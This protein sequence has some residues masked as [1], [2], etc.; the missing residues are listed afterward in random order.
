[1]PKTNRGPRVDTRLHPD[2]LD[3]LEQLCRK[4]SMT[5]TA[6]VRE[7]ILWYLHSHERVEDEKRTSEI[8]LLFKKMTDRICGYLYKVGVDSNTTM[9]FLR[10]ISDDDEREAFEECR[11][12]A[13]DYM[14]DKL[15][16]EEREAAEGLI[17]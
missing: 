10:E 13:V 12:L 2:D 15:T 4:K 1:M 11:E 9:R 16:P 3:K 17:G 8:A 14:H 5:R 6:L 7:A